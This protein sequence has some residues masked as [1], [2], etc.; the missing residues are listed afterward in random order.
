MFPFFASNDDAEALLE[1]SSI[2]GKKAMIELATKLSECYL[3]FIIIINAQ[4]A[5]K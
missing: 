1:I 4:L 5:I 3:M 2:Y